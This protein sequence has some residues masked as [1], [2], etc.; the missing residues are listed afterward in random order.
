MSV[1]ES[2]PEFEALLNNLKQYCGYDLTGYKRTTLTRRFQRRMQNLGIENYGNYWQYIQE[3]HE[4][5]VS[6][7]NTI[8]INFSD[9]FRD[10]EHWDYL[11]KE[12]LPQIIANKQPHEKIRV[13]SAGCA[14]GQELYTLVM[15]LA[16][17]FGIKQYLERVQI[18]A[19]DMDEDAL[20]QARKA[21]YSDKEVANIPSELL[22]KY[23]EKT[24]EQY[25]FDLKLRLPIIFGCHD[26]AVNAPMSKI[27]LLVCRNVL[28]YFNP[29]T[30]ATILVRFH[31]ALTDKGFLFLGNA[32]SLSNNRYIYTPV[33][34]K[35]RVFAKG[36]NLGLEEHLLIRPQTLNMTRVKSLTTRTQIWKAAFEGSLFPQIAVDCSGCLLLANPQAYTLFGLKSSDR[37]GQL[38]DLEI[39]RVVNSSAIMRKLECNP[40]PFSLKDIKWVGEED[41]IYL[42]IH[43]VP[44]F[45]PSG[46]LRGANLTF[47]EVT[48]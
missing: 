20:K 41:I 40:H 22:S 33:S 1:L 6:L 10:P 17:S 42:D 24:K 7:L 16:E 26:L 2:N 39:G 18:F 48:R 21:S 29:Q 47:I 31:F 15:L 36:E 38:E 9:F 37:G 5:C 13:W 11:A 43:I 30:Q 45:D 44:I 27:D 25:V 4:E 8:L 32:E 46:K 35:H 34:W 28:M 14:S 23:F 19:T 12:I 3:H